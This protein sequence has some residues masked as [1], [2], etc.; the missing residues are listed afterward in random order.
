ML[1]SEHAI[2]SFDYTSMRVLPDRLRRGRDDVYIG[3][4]ETCLGIYRS[5]VGESRKSLHREVENVLTEL[6]CC[7][8][9]RVAAFCKLLDDAATFNSDKSRAVKLRQRVFQIASPLHPIVSVR[10]GIFEHGIAEA[11]ARVCKELGMEWPDIASMMFADVIELQRLA[12]FDDTMTGFD[13][14][15][16]Y[17]VAQT[18]AALYRATRVWIDARS[19]FKTILGQAKLAGLMHRIERLSE[20]DGIP[21]YRFKLDGPGSVLRSTT[22]YGIRFAQMIPTLLVCR[23]WHLTA[24][25]LTVTKHRMRMTL[26]PADGLRSRSVR[27]DSFDSEIERTIDARWRVAPVEG[28]TWRR[29]ADLLVR[30]QS[31]MTPDFS[32]THPQTGRKLLIEV[33]GFWTPEYIAEKVARLK[34]FACEEESANL[35]WLLI[36]P[37]LPIPEA[38]TDLGL[39]MTCL[40]AR[41]RPIDW[42]KSVG[43][44]E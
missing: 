1:R 6:G 39:S 31:V 14:L 36:F 41:D 32:I 8:P 17:N 38:I 22:R 29:E 7:P 18:Q 35:Q 26:N 27:P 40:R 16:R 20:K 28:W 9:R 25:I 3:A 21:G 30:G 43:W 11:Q 42:L 33:V 4:A 37:K 13:F 12:S 19:D 2:I 24:E 15:S 34:A 5:G 44:D 10:E 23:D